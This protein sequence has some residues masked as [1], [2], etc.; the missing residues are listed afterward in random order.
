[1]G[2]EFE[3]YSMKAMELSVQDGCVLWGS[4]VVIPLALRPAVIQLLHEGHPRMKAIARGMIWW[5]VMDVEL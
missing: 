4:R 5:P 1:M 3:Q 2:Q